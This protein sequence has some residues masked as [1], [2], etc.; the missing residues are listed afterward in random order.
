MLERLLLYSMAIALYSCYSAPRRTDDRL[1]PEDQLVRGLDGCLT[2]MHLM[3]FDTLVHS[4]CLPFGTQWGQ[5][6]SQVDGLE[7][8]SITAFIPVK[9]SP[10]MYASYVDM[11]YEREM[12]NFPMAPRFAVESNAVVHIQVSAVDPRGSLPWSEMRVSYVAGMNSKYELVHADPDTLSTLE[13]ITREMML[14]HKD[15][16]L[17]GKAWSIKTRN[18]VEWAYELWVRRIA[19]TGEV[20]AG[21]TAIIEDT[22]RSVLISAQWLRKDLPKDLDE[23]RSDGMF[24][25]FNEV[26]ESCKWR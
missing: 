2:G 1:G 10:K 19:H 7:R 16:S 17:A 26:V 5:E 15:P 12:D 18:G 3:L 11:R 23:V 21:I 4:V 20:R 14:E 8:L 13:R 22:D 6:R 24:V 9:S 25:I